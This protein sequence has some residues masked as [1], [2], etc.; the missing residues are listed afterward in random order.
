MSDYIILIPIAIVIV[1]IIGLII[2]LVKNSKKTKE[3]PTSILDV[4]EVGVPSS[5]EFSYGYEKEETVVMN[6]I[7]VEN[8]EVKEEVPNVQ[9]EVSQVQ[10]ENIVTEPVELNP[11][12]VENNEQKEEFP[13][14]TN[15]E[16]TNE[17]NNINEE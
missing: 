14:I 11:I 8:T 6:P 13:D 1:I 9:E 17:S 10:P 5:S 15:D 3:E 16:I 2:Y 4:N 12:N 7:N